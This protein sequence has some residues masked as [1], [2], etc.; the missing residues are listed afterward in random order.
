MLP[1]SKN[2]SHPEFKKKKKSSWIAQ[3][4]SFASA[5]LPRWSR[6][7]EEND[8]NLKHRGVSPHMPLTCS[9]SPFLSPDLWYSTSCQNYTHLLWIRQNNMEM[10]K[11]GVIIHQDTCLW[12]EMRGAYTCQKSG[13]D[14]VL[15]LNTPVFL[16]LV[17]FMNIT[18]DSMPPTPPPPNRQTYFTSELL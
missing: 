8:K 9:L 1:T 18:Q 5:L 17:L 2:K 7:P 14:F 4:K 3:G 12:R 6:S 13:D 10:L 16:R 11:C 15:V